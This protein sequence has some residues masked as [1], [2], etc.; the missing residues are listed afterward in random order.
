MRL[1][2]L[3]PLVCGLAMLLWANPAVAWPPGAVALC[4]APGEQS[5][6]VAVA[7]GAGGV[8]AAWAD[9]RSVDYDV[10]LQHL[11][12]TGEPAAG[13][14]YE[15]LLVGGGEGHQLA[16]QVALDANGACWIVWKDTGTAVLRMRKLSPTLEPGFIPG[17]Q[18]MTRPIPASTEFVLCLSGLGQLFIFYA[19]GAPG[20][21][22]QV[23]KSAGGLNDPQAM[24]IGG[25]DANN[26]SA[27]RTVPDGA[28]GALVVWQRTKNSAIDLAVQRV[29]PGPVIASGWPVNGAVLCSAA[30]VQE[31]PAIV[32]DG[33]GGL[34]ATWAD[35]RAGNSDIYLARITASGATP[36]DWPLNGI[37]LCS[38]S[39]AQTLPAL[40]RLG[41][42]GVLV[43]W[44]DSRVAN[45]DIYATS[46]SSTGVRD[47]GWPVNGGVVSA[48]VNIQLT[49]V[50]SSS[51][52][53]TAYLAWA[54]L[55]GG[56][57]FDLSMAR[58]SAHG[59]STP[60][61]NG[62]LLSAVPNDQV[63]PVIVPGGANDAIVL[64]QDFRDNFAD[65]YVQRV[66]LA[67]P[68][69][70]P[71]LTRSERG[72]HAWPQ[73]A[74]AGTARVSFALADDTPATLTLFDVAGRAVAP[75]EVVSGRGDHTRALG[76]ASLAP[77]LYLARL[78]H[79]GAT[80]TASVVVVR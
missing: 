28:G 66:A 29:S 72:L 32:A 25:A 17:G 71:P 30:G 42:G 20:A 27:L 23:V 14:P 44:E 57:A 9:L 12:A 13:Y 33:E 56:V 41:T 45:T 39:G 8:Y 34:F 68:L 24:S 51:T 11:D 80:R 16:P 15:G 54:T 1:V 58:A 67:A 64:W 62:Y 77:G 10:Y 22:V 53:G 59:G 47:T 26:N 49:P 5:G 48:A 36:S 63:S 31:S 52:D 61:G 2:L 60:G 50:A 19:T 46:W 74:R 79:A 43:V 75:P 38:A 6:L 65:L 69:E 70:A 78:V 21:P 7:D 4:L 73:P 3:A 76:T 40:T 18:A 55:Q 35:R 37:A